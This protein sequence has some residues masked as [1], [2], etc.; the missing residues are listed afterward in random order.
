MSRILIVVGVLLLLLAVVF[1]LL[2][3]DGLSYFYHAY[4]VNFCFFLSLS[5][6]GLFF[7]AL[8]HASR[9]GWSVAV[10]RVAEILAANTLLMALLFLP[11]LVPL[12]FGSSVLYKWLD[13]DVVR[14]DAILAG[15]SA[16]LNLPFFVTRAVAFF[17]V[18]GALVWYFWRRS[19]EQDETG[20]ASLTLR[21]ER[22]SYPALLVFAVTIT[23]AAV[24]WI[25]S[26]TPHWYSTIFG[27]YYF[28]GAVVGC[29]AA[30]ILILTGLQRTGRLL[31]SVTVEH[32]HELGKLL[33]AFTIF[34]GYIAFSQYLLIWYANIPEETTW[35]LPRQR[36]GWVAVSLILLFGH[37]LIPFV[38]LISREA[39]RRP[40]ILAFWAAWLL[41]MHWLDVH[42]LI[43]PNVEI[44]GL[45]V[46]PID[47]FC[48][49][50]MGLL[51]LAGFLL[52][53]GSRPLTPMRDPRLGESL[54][55]ENS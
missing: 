34:W 17:A 51:Y 6:G 43:M 33:F 20:D 21:M 55:F 27:V 16:Y 19:L 10:R 13:P 47:V 54:G 9:A 7:V 15:K 28:S 30:V 45:P 42:Y 41:V 11:I 50:G 37:L 22:V 1:G 23:F 46:G 5:L 18:W 31:E 32:Y 12:L 25:M 2:R 39:K 44:I 3:G 48:L 24:D 26:L 8:Q 53:A 40:A 4:L 14:A 29:L 38:G 52:W 35:Y 36:G 49:F